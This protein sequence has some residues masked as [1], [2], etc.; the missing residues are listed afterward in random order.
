MTGLTLPHLHDTH[1]LPSALFVVSAV[2]ATLAVYISTVSRKVL[3]ALK[4]P[5]DI[6]SWLSM[7]P[8][9]R[10]FPANPQASDGTKNGTPPPLHERRRRNSNT[11]PAPPPLITQDSE[12]HQPSLHAALV[13]AMPSMLLQISLSCIL[14]ALGSYFGSIWLR[15]LTVNALKVFISCIF[16]IFGFIGFYYIPKT[17]KDI[18]LEQM[19]RFRSPSAPDSETAVA[20]D[21]ELHTPRTPRTTPDRHD[22][23][24]S[25]RRRERA[26]GSWRKP[27]ISREQR[28]A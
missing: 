24:S 23:P 18:E 3:G 27:S 2:G 11:R 22:V 10:Q 17:L 26:S 20:S 14:L 25:A 5:V 19:D 1:W 8:S 21:D 12:R 4:A 6:R 16:G 28:R 15:C 13:L 7:P 9:G